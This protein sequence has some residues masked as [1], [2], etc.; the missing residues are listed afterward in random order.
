MKHYFFCAVLYAS[1]SCEWQKISL[2]T[3]LKVYLHD[4]LNIQ[5]IIGQKTYYVV[6]DVKVKNNKVFLI[7]SKSGSLEFIGI[8]LLTKKELFAITP[9][10]NYCQ[11][12]TNFDVCGD[13]LS[14]FCSFPDVYKVHIKTGSVV[15]KSL[16]YNN[17]V[18]MPTTI[19]CSKNQM[20]F[21]HDVYGISF[22]KIV[23]RELKRL[24]VHSD[25]ISSEWSVPSFPINDTLNLLSGATTDHNTMKLSAI[26]HFNEIKWT[27]SIRYPAKS[28]PENGTV[29]ILSYNNTFVVKY[30]NGIESLSKKDGKQLWVYS[31][32]NSLEF[33]DMIHY[34][35]KNVF[36]Y[37]DK[38]LE[39][40]LVYYHQQEQFA[41][42]GKTGGGYKIILKMYHNE[43]G[44]EYWNSS[45]GVL[46]YHI[47]GIFK[48]II[49]VKDDDYLY[50]LSIKT[51]KLV[52]KSK[53]QKQNEKSYNFDVVIDETTGKHYLNLG[54]K[55]LYW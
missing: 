45:L 48:D 24:R 15:K 12:Y 22:C 33:E 51:G 23:D 32:N 11:L 43:T 54:N 3:Q 47:L 1:F 20:F 29:G 10:D 36:R 26:N 50:F 37:K 55:M 40:R 44:K 21:Y 25:L 41:D 18:G 49:V 4:S 28:P 52:S 39:C 46:T 5:E 7:I 9:V 35:K 14:Y 53:I 6:L 42:I 8:D 38:V 16:K 17:G 30:P 19:A 2:P 27:H 34:E 13:T 31:S